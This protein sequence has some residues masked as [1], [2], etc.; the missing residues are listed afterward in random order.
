M[1]IT[2]DDLRAVD[3]I[4]NNLKPEKPRYVIIPLN[5]ELL[6]LDLEKPTDLATFQEYLKK[7]D[8]T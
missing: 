8:A 4:I 2:E 3:K 7:N 1:N 6:H 5:E